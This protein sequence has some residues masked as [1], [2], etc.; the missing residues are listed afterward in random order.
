MKNSI[1]LLT[2]IFLMTSV[3]GITGIVNAAT[4][5]IKETFDGGTVGNGVFTTSN[6]STGTCTTDGWSFAGNYTASRPIYQEKVTGQSADKVANIDMSNTLTYTTEMLRYAHVA[7]AA[8]FGGKV[9][10][11]CDVQPVINTGTNASGYIRLYIGSLDNTTTTGSQIGFGIASNTIVIGTNNFTTTTSLNVQG[12]TFTSTSLNWLRFSMV[13]DNSVSPK[14]VTYTVKNLTNGKTYADNVAFDK[15][16]AGAINIPMLSVSYRNKVVGAQYMRIDNLTYAPYDFVF[17]KGITQLGV[18]IKDKNNNNLSYSGDALHINDPI[19]Q[20]NINATL[21][22]TYT[23]DKSMKY[24]ATAYDS[25]NKLVGLKAIDD[26]LPAYTNNQIV[27]VSGLDISKAQ[28]IKLLCLNS[29]TS[30]APYI[31]V[32]RINIIRDVMKVAY[33]G[34]SITLGMSSTDINTK[35][36]R[37]LTTAWLQQQFPTKTVSEIRAAIG[38]TGSDLGTCRIGED[39]LQYIP[40]VLFVEFAVNDQGKPN[41]SSYF[42]KMYEGIVRQAKVNNPQM[43]IYFLYSFSKYL[44]GVYDVGGA[45]PCMVASTEIANYYGIPIIDMGRDLYNLHKSTGATIPGTYM[46]DSSHPTDAGHSQYAQSIQNYFATRLSELTAKTDGVIPTPKYSN[47][48]VGKMLDF[49]NSTNG[50]LLEG[51]WTTNTATIFYRPMKTYTSNSIGQ[52]L[53]FTFNGVGFGFF[54]ESNTN[55]GQIKY[56]VDGGAYKIV[57]TKAASYRFSY[58]ILEIGLTNGIH[59]VEI[60]TIDTNPVEFAGIITFTEG[61]SSLTPAQYTSI[62]HLK[63]NKD[64]AYSFTTD[65]S[66]MNSV[67][68]YDSVFKSIK[69][70]NG[71]QLRASLMMV[72][73]FVGVNSDSGNWAYWQGLVSEGNFDVVNHF[74]THKVPGGVTD[75]YGPLSETDLITEV[76]GGRSDLM[77]KF[78]NQDIIVVANPNVSNTDTADKV[79]KQY[80]YA[81]RNGSGGSYNTL[82][83]TEDNWFRLGWQQVMSTSTSIGMNAWVD[84]AI[85]SKQWLIELAHGVMNDDG[86]GGQGSSP[87][88]KGE[89]SAHFNYVATK[90]DKLWCGTINEVTKYIRERQNSTIIEREYSSSRI[91][92]DLVCHLDRAVFAYPLTMKTEVPANWVSV[93]VTQNGASNTYSSVVEGTKRYVY[94]DVIP[95]KG[96]ISLIKN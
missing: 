88:K 10:F 52:K 7:N 61:G 92:Y 36:Y 83:P 9:Y 39:V 70:N 44:N 42:Q 22:N 55:N 14:T 73:G 81:A 6:V 51:T 5:Y 47:Y 78:P 77:A 3:P 94:Y 19:D 74:K 50:I 75:S 2:F 60:E 93:A 96:I 8:D 57:D 20:V 31:P 38:S 28:Y 76:N 25:N 56:S 90:L 53:A 16:Y 30:V 15:A 18:S 79:D 21:Q 89:I 72:P 63:D 80:H 86:T 49:V 12:D 95:N 23:T 64:A 17:P 41:T 82:N 87:V 24:I 69:A 65:D 66:L 13:V 1:L 67:M 71:V 62:T 26:T 91:T 11:S 40:D 46:S 84:N 43:K 85:A 34:G 35:S 29:L 4:P 27:T 33:L 32:T 48:L 37:A 59:T 54:G 45:E 68:Y 58:P